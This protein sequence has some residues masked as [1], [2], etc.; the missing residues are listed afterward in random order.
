MAPFV[1]KQ[2]VNINLAYPIWKRLRHLTNCT[3]K[4]TKYIYWTAR[5]ANSGINWEELTIDQLDSWDVKYHSLNMGKPHYDVWI[6]D[7]AINAHDFK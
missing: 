2:L 5:G 7:K 4:D 3:N 6:D 1:A